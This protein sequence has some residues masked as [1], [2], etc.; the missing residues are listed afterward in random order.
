[1]Q[2]MPS[3]GEYEAIKFPYTPEQ[4][5][6]FRVFLSFTTTGGTTTLKEDGKNILSVLLRDVSITTFI[7]S[8]KGKNYTLSLG[9]VSSSGFEFLPFS[10]K[11]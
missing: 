9:G 4:D 3:W 8:R 2:K 7:P 6:V 10:F 5:G 1:M 11:S